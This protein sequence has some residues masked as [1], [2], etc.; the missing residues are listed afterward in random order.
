MEALNTL[1]G[2]LTEGQANDH[3]SQIKKNY[4][5]M[6]NLIFKLNVLLCDWKKY[7]GLGQQIYIRHH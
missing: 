6:L 1:A 2:E 4:L 3:E 5:G 7:G